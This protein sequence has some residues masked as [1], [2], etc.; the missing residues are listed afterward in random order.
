[1]DPIRRFAKPDLHRPRALIAFEGWNDAGDAASGA[2]TYLLGQFDAEPFA[3]I[4]PEE[5]F[6]FQSQRPEV[7][8]AEGGGRRIVWP[9]TRFYSIAVAGH[10]H[11]LVVVLG[12]EPHLRWRT[13]SLQVAA[14][15]DE[16]GVEEAVLLGSFIGRVAH[17]LPVPIIGVASDPDLI[18]TLGLL[19][20]NYEGP[21]GIVG[22]LLQTL[23]DEG[24]PS[25]SL[26]AA[27]PH[28]L[29]ANPNPK[30]MLAL[31]D[32]AGGLAGVTVDATELSRV[33]GEF[34][35]RVNAALDE[36]EELTDYVAA[37]EKEAGSADLSVQL[38]E[39]GANRLI[40][41][42]ED[43]LRDRPG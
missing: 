4:D 43:F 6:D 11:D 12:E 3:A 33:A 20:S 18:A 41:E 42:V 7:E 16:V 26:W 19:P 40:R 21:T 35:S 23:Q 34:E 38:R 24:I 15:L 36:S 9:A 29:S 17:T 39:E 31:L 30:A 10:D 37:L 22:V 14:L 8:I 13:F 32:R 28:Y 1:M 25:V 2:L 27:V 5:F